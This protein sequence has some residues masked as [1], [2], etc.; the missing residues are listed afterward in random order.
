MSVFR[1][2]IVASMIFGLAGCGGS[3][4]KYAD[5][6]DLKSG[7]GLFSGDDG[8]FTLIKIDPVD[9][10]NDEQDT[11]SQELPPEKKE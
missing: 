2:V 9:A 10:E 3:D 5:N 1:S 6:R 8:V 7:P 11:E 4:F